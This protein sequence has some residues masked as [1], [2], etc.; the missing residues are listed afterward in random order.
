MAEKMTPRIEDVHGSGVY[1]GTGPFPKG[2]ATVRSP[3]AFAHPEERRPVHLDRGRL[4]KAAL[5]AGR[6]LF[7]GYFLYNGIN[8]F[9]NRKAMVDYARSKGTPFPALAV[10]V[11]GLM[12]LAGGLST[13][14]GKRP[15]LGASLIA[16]FLSGVSPQMHAFW[17][18][19]DPQQRTGEMV[20]FMKNMALVGATLLT[21][22]QREP[23]SRRLGGRK[24]SAGALV[25]SHS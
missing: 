9:R 11:T 18:V 2:E 16:T 25:P 12:L 22:A 15:K 7:G 14:A 17:R 1:P 13:L 5:L 20:N 6:V 3:A 4:E 24:S 10:P 8:H 19:S 23:G 21:M